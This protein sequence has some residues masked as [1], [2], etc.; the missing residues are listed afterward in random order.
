M[1]R[2]ITLKLTNARICH[3]TPDTYCIGLPKKLVLD[4]HLKVGDIINVSIEIK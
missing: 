4:G 2:K 3:R 1:A